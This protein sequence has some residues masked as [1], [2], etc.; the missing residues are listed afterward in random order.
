MLIKNKKYIFSILQFFI[1]IFAIGYLI[2]LI[3]QYLPDIKVLDIKINPTL[4]FL[5][6][7]VVTLSL[8]LWAII[9]S[10]IINSLSIKKNELSIIV[11]IYI[12]SNLTKYLPG[13]VWNYVLRDFYGKTK[14]IESKKIWMVNYIE[15][16]GSVFSGSLIYLLSLLFNHKNS[17]IINPLFILFLTIIILITISPPFVNYF[18]SIIS[19]KG[20]IQIEKDFQYNWKIFFIFIS[21]SMLN[22]IFVCTGVF[23]F[24]ASIV[25]INPNVLPEIFGIW[26]ISI[27]TGLVAVG[28]PQG[29]GIRESIMIFLLS[30]LIGFASATLIS[31]SSRV[32]LLA[33][34]L[35][36]YLLWLLIRLIR[37]K[38]IH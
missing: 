26:S 28:V 6:T 33:C 15:I 21:F 38:I 24:M 8:I 1:T 32:W 23:I 29:I 36:S 34:D 19:R 4:L 31:V 5:S 25:E 12:T 7:I 10:K 22:W 2:F 20:N 14:G 13:S 16:L 35:L 9:W 27:V 17:P 30:L 3:K 11:N 37:N 18:F